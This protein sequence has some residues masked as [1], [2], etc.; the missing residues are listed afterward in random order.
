MEGFHCFSRIRVNKRGYFN[1]FSL[2]P[3]LWRK[4]TRVSDMNTRPPTLR[5]NATAFHFRQNPIPLKTYGKWKFEES[6]EWIHE[7]INFNKD[8]QGLS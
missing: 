2:F 4:E 1:A 3:D 7:I 6:S 8:S 5:V